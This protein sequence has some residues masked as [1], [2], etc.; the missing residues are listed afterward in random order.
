MPR[1]MQLALKDNDSLL[2]P[3]EANK[4][5]LLAEMRNQLYSAPC[6]A[7]VP[8]IQTPNS[9]LQYTRVSDPVSRTVSCLRRCSSCASTRLPVVHGIQSESVG[10]TI[11][12]RFLV[13]TCAIALPQSRSD[14]SSF[15]SKSYVHMYVIP[16]FEDLSD[17]PSK[18]T[19]AGHLPI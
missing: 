12:L 6:S 9:T 2:L 18:V 14:P 5:C 3:N 15:H 11:A 4:G 17:S 8:F 13:M 19:L 1:R 10:V 7:L 16:V